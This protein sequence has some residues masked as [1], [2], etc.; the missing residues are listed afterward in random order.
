MGV[1]LV[2]P[3]MQRWGTWIL[4][5]LFIVWIALMWHAAL[6]LLAI[7]SFALIASASGGPE[8]LA[9]I[10]YFGILPPCIAALGLD[11]WRKTRFP[12]LAL[13]PALVAVATMLST[14]SVSNLLFQRT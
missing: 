8:L 12:W 3:K 6:P 2:N 10:I 11:L 5:A 1:V 9:T 14:D 7:A 13:G 4:S